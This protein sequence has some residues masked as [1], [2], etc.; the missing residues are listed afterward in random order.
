ME[1]RFCAVLAADVAEYTRLM[2]ADEEG[3]H[4]RLMRIKTELLDPDITRRNG[5]VVKNTGDGFLAKFDSVLDATDCALN[6]QD[7]LGDRGAF[8]PPEARIAFRMGLN[9]CDTIVEADDIYGEGVNIAARL[10]TFAEPGGIVL[11]ASVVDGLGGDL[12]V[13]LTDLGELFLKN[14]KRPVRAFSVRTDK[15][16][17]KA[18]RPSPTV[19]SR[20][21]IA[22]VPFERYANDEGATYFAGGIVDDIVGALAGLKELFVI[23]RA[24]TLAY[25]SSPVDIKSVG[26]DLSVRYVLS[27][28]VHR[29]GQ[30]LR[31]ST[32]LSETET[33][34][35]LWA[36]RHN[37]HISE[38]FELQDRI[39][40]RVVATI[41][42]HVRERE[43]QRA[44]RKHPDN[45]DAYDLVLQGMDLIYRMDYDAFSRGRGLLQHAIATDPTYAP[46]YA[47][48]AQWHTIR[49]AQGWTSDPQADCEE[50]ARL[51]AAA[52]VHDKYDASALAIYG[53]AR[54]F[55]LKDYHVGQSFLDR[56]L[57][58]SPNNALAWNL[59]SCTHSYLGNGATA[60]AHAEHSLRLSPL[61]PFDFFYLHNLGMAHYTN[62][63]YEEAAECGLRALR[64]N[65][66]HC[67]NMRV[68]TASLMALGRTEEARETARTL[69]S[70][71]PGFRLSNYAPV[72][73]FSHPDRRTLFVVRLRQAGLPN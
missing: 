18:A 2:E 30:A 60:V 42:P 62:G 31:I 27:G 12:I 33:G 49:V 55:L 32:E 46:A 68:L 20:P 65:G 61:D 13:P 72:C 40:M 5:T 56:A 53:H 9:L 17:G 7:A 26:R 59:S 44:L 66:R 28:S 47:Y 36:E 41:A 19:D 38:L 15:P 22:V 10:Q 51:A 23:S 45:M 70:V 39:S 16:V 58:A 1:R 52:I 57:V 63:S 8:D 50:A 43:L 73:P 71:Q 4:A 37:G 29:A 69:L 34:S 24:S 35:I 25:R 3:T 14:L 64:R 54:S 11:S 67:A 48:A 6:L 21:S